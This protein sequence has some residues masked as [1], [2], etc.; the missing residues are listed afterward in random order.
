MTTRL[1]VMMPMATAALLV[2][3]VQTIDANDT[4]KPAR[5]IARS[6]SSEG[7]ATRVPTAS[8]KY[9]LFGREL[10]CRVKT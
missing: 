5:N 9:D 7:W 2:A 6:A 3:T 8:S 10:I 4:R 1:L